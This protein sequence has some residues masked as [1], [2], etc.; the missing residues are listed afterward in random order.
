MSR[1]AFEQITVPSEIDPGSK[2]NICKVDVTK[3]QSC[4]DILGNP[5][6]CILSNG[7]NGAL[8]L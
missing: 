6:Y 3:R 4:G 2:I 7:A 5:V 8:L 1:P